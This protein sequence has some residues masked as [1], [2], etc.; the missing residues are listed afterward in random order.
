VKPHYNKYAGTV[1]HDCNLNCSSG[2]VGG[3]LLEVDPEQKC[4]PLSEKQLKPKKKKKKEER[5]GG[6]SGEGRGEIDCFIQGNYSK[7]LLL[8]KFFD[9]SQNR[10]GVAGFPL[11]V[12]KM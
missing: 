10:A 6:R 8:C 9:C 3:F 2:I 12:G 1:A 4:K 5:R 11:P 7:N